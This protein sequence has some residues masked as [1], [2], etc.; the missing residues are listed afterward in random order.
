MFERVFGGAREPRV[1]PEVNATS[2]ARLRER[3]A[4]L[5]LAACDDAFWT[6]AEA[7]DGAQDWSR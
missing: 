3:A 5:E 6:G 4:R 2:D 7:G 1:H